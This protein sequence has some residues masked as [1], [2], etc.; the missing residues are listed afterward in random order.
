MVSGEVLDVAVDL[1]KNSATFGQHVKIILNDVNKKQFFIPRGFAHGFAVLSE[2]AIFSY[3]VDNSY[4]PE[5][6]ESLYWNDPDLAI[7]WGFDESQVILSQKDLEAKFFKH[8]I[9]PF[10]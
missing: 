3:K 5:H 8:F 9:T 10:E 4:A 2:S 6:E 1:R 7:D